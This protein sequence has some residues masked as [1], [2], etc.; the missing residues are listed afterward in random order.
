MVPIKWT[1]ENELTIRMWALWG[2][3]IITGTEFRTRLVHTLVDLGWNDLHVVECEWYILYPQLRVLLV[4]HK[5]WTIENGLAIL[6][7]AH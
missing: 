3:S 7:W 2:S 6:I 5:K 4:V 1:I